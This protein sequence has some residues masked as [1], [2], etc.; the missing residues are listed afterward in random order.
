MC[1]KLAVSDFL[2]V[3]HRPPVFQAIYTDCLLYRYTSLILVVFWNTGG[4]AMFYKY[5]SFLVDYKAPKL[6]N[7][8]KYFC[9]KPMTNYH[10]NNKIKTFF[11]LF[12]GWN[13][14]PYR[15]YIATIVTALL[16][17]DLSFI[18]WYYKTFFVYVLYI[19][20]CFTVFPRDWLPLSCSGIR[21]SDMG[22]TF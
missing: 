1:Y 22:I 19:D 20:Q 10:T 16:S 4:G 7:I 2:S 18:L 5:L 9:L 12:L 3:E 15:A 14:F 11:L 17:H 8:R 6:G 13:F 21:T